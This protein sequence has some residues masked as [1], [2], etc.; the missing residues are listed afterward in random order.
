MGSSRV[1]TA[2]YAAPGVGQEKTALAPGRSEQA[3]ER[4]I[5]KS[6][7]EL[8]WLFRD[9][10]SW[11][12]IVQVQD[13]PHQVICVPIILERGNARWLIRVRRGHGIPFTAHAHQAKRP[14]VVCIAGHD[15]VTISDQSALTPGV[16]GD[17]LHRDLTSKLDA[18]QRARPVIKRTKFLALTCHVT[19]IEERLDA[20]QG[21][22]GR[23][24]EVALR[25]KE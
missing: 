5:V 15:A 24:T 18:L 6:T 2:R 19:W 13:I 4:V 8:I 25:L 10:I 20:V 14:F 17:V 16:V 3:I 23:G 22:I 9:A 1:L 11:R 21:I 12:P 7:V